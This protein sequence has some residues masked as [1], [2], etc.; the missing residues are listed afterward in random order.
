MACCLEH[1]MMSKSVQDSVHALWVSLKEALAEL[2]CVRQILSILQ[3]LEGAGI[4]LLL[5]AERVFK[6]ACMFIPL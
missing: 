5:Y 3:R 4:F 2:S 6:E 1:L